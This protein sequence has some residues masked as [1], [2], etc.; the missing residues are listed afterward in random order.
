MDAKT[1]RPNVFISYSWNPTINKEKVISLAERLSSDGVHVT[2][3][4]WDLIEGQDKNLFMEQMVNSDEIDK[5]LLICN[6]D[7][8]EKANKRIGGVGIESL[9]ISSEIYSQAKQTKFIPIIFEFDNENKPFIPT[10]VDGRI[11]IDLSNDNNFED[12]YELLIRNLFGKPVSKRPPIGSPP[13]YVLN[14]EP[15][16]LPTSNKVTVIKRALLDEKKNAILF[17]Q[18]YYDTFIRSLPS[19]DI[20]AS[21]LSIPDYDEV[22]L[23]SI[24]NMRPLRDDFINFL[25]TYLGHSVEI[26]IE[27]MHSFFEKLLNFFLN[28]TDT[29][30]GTIGA[31]KNDNYRFFF[32][33]L[34]LSFTSIMIEK[35]RFAELAFILHNSY[36]IFIERFGNSQEFNFQAF[37]RHVDTLNTHRKER[38]HLTRISVTADLLKERATGAIKFSQLQE[39]DAL[40]YYISLLNSNSRYSWFP[41][42]SCYGLYNLPVISK[43]VSQRF[44]DKLKPILNVATKD[45]LEKRIIGIEEKNRDNINRFHYELPEVRRGLR[46]EEL[47]TLR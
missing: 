35:E 22:I 12:N 3:D 20:E 7:Y 26:D 13:P 42:T 29:T 14:E 1:T 38:L 30:Q 9:I 28:L 10:F 36:I 41:E 34:F 44:F 21:S 11:F 40:L 27:R 18:D 46:L 19:F 16:F 24:D 39:A 31:L 43:A 17:I 5:V 2:I 4:I 6:K 37:R 33:E 32:V 8:A 15:I 47:C 45:E 25:E 23:W